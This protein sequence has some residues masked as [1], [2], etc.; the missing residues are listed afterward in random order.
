M[1][2]CPLPKATD[3]APNLPT[4]TPSSGKGSTGVDAT[5]QGVGETAGRRG[6]AQ[7]SGE[8][9]VCVCGGT[10]VHTD[11]RSQ[12]CV[13]D[14]SL[15]ARVRASSACVCVSAHVPSC[16][17]R[18]PGLRL[19][20]RVP[21]PVCPC[22]SKCS[23]LRPPRRPAGSAQLDPGAVRA[24]PMRGGRCVINH[25]SL[26]RFQVAAAVA[27]PGGADYGMLLLAGLQL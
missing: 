25:L 1:E 10:R 14:V 3:A 2:S 22:V 24:C 13:C 18:L 21:A 9:A 7:S 6:G 17:A 4:A 26:S 23:P 16:L 15:C 27:S 12:V 20:P 5:T 8:R 19:S 11:M